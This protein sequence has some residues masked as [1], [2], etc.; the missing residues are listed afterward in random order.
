VGTPDRPSTHLLGRGT[1]REVSRIAKVLRAET[2][3]GILLVAAAA[4]AL[5]WANSR[6]ATPTGRWLSCAS[7]RCT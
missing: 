1:W 6:G 3:G 4:F 5:A 7:E 2:V